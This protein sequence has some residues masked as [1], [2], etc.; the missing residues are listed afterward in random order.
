MR[1]LK[2]KEINA[3]YRPSDVLDLRKS[4]PGKNKQE[5]EPPAKNEVKHQKTLERCLVRA[6]CLLEGE[7]L[8]LEKIK[9]S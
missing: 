4:K 3:H 7:R 1:N 5:R 9:V 8:A 2:K 6:Y